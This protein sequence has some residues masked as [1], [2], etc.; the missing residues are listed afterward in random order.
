MTAASLSAR[1]ALILTLVLTL[2]RLA[3]QWSV[4]SQ[5]GS[6]SIIDVAWSSDGEYIAIA[7]ST[8]IDVVPA[9]GTAP[10]VTVQV[11]G[12]LREVAWNFDN[13]LIA[14]ASREGVISIIQRST[15]S[16]IA[17]LQGETDWLLGNLDWHPSENL[18][19]LSVYDGGR[20]VSDVLVWN[21][22][23]E[24]IQMR[25]A[26][27]AIL[28]SGE[29]IP[30]IDWHDDGN[31]LAFALAD[32]VKVW[33]FTQ[34]RVVAEFQSPPDPELRPVR[35]DALAWKP[36]DDILAVAALYSGLSLW[37]AETGQ[38]TGPMAALQASEVN[39]S[40]GGQYLAFSDGSQLTIADGST[41]QVLRVYTSPTYAWEFSW[42]DLDDLVLNQRRNVA[43]LDFDDIP[44]V[45][46]T[47]ALAST[48]V[49]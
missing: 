14:A 6:P 29:L 48:P 8:T 10:A 31:R 17:T 35:V 39:W 38:V 30:A 25:V 26:E 23:I 46:P 42:N 3:Q 11:I 16:V 5:S 45:T 32:R 34:Q 18:L 27:E 43:T 12:D 13:T 21:T 1:A 49:P 22:D 15:Y 44:T 2:T 47:H 41:L 4:I 36:D 20:R 7:F 28:L 19:A 33:D 37:N 24:Q 40:P 9:Q